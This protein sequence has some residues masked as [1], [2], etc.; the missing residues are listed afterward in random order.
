MTVKSILKDTVTNVII[1]LRSCVDDK[2][3]IT[4]TSKVIL[5]HHKSY[6]H[7]LVEWIDVNKNILQ[8]GILRKEDN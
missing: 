6:L 4:A 5:N 2:L 7:H 3:Y 1:E 8:L